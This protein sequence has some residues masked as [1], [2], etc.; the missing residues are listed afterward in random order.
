MEDK[1]IRLINVIQTDF[2][3]ET[4]P[5]LAIANVL[6]MTEDEVI[7]LIKQLKETGYIRRLGGIFDSR[8][9]GY[10]SRLCAM[11]VEESRVEETASIINS[12]QGVTHNYLRN[13]QYNIWFTLIT[14]SEIDM[15][16]ILS[17]IKHLSGISDI[18]VLDALKTFK[19]RVN[20]NLGGS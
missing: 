19:I 20:F 6:G 11:Q 10:T 4:R 15:E 1:A 5:Y 8:S 2:P 17:E 18:M 13:H 16:R 12:Y 14:P 9:L 7:S 3:I